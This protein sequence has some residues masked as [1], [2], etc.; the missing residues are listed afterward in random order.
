MGTL[1]IWSNSS[2]GGIVFEV[3]DK[4]GTVILSWLISGKLGSTAGFF[5]FVSAAG[6]FGF[7][8]EASRSR[9]NNRI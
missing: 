2:S 1:Q 8:S 3:R 9:K 5:G 4:S 7:T 6:F